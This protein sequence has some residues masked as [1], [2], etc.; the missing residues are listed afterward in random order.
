[1]RILSVDA[2]EFV[3]KH[4]MH[5]AL[6]AVLGEENYWGSNLDALHD[7]LTCIFEPTELHIRNW[8]AAMQILGDYANRLWT[9]LDDSSEENPLLTIVI[10]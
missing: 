6:R 10:E 4:E 5:A 1:M 9:V 2:R 3:S 7:C 8:S